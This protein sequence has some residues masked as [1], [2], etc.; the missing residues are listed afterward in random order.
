M[1]DEQSYTGIFKVGD[2]VVVAVDNND[3]SWE[4]EEGTV[5]KTYWQKGGLFGGPRNVE[6]V[7]PDIDDEDDLAE[8]EEGRAEL[9]RL[10][11]DGDCQTLSSDQGFEF[12]AL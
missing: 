9:L 12:E 2:R 3:G 8:T 7:V 4:G 11:E 5:I 10:Y 1:S 6:I